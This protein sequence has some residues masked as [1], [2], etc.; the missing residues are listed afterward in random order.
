M[1]DPSH[2]NAGLF[3]VYG[4][5]TPLALAPP[6]APGRFAPW[7]QVDVGLIS[8]T[9]TMRRTATFL[10]LAAL[11]VATA[12]LEAG[13]APQP[14]TAGDKTAPAVARPQGPVF[15]KAAEGD[16]PTVVRDAATHAEPA[17]VVVYVG[18]T[19]CEP[20]MEFHRAVEAG[21]LDEA[22]AGVT[23][24]EFDLD[25]DGDRLDAAGYTGRYIPRF[26]VP[27][28]DGTPSPKSIE[29]G[30]KGQGAV[31]HIMQRLGPLVADAAAG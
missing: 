2:C 13:P 10:C 23:F 28:A 6:A 21:S 22:L 30:I 19:W 29:G 12:C 5:L 3:E 18:A 20:C 14:R 9:E 25:E 16:V 4:P 7:R 27:N 24:V 15:V 17:P 26:T 11:L 31:E 1:H 8:F